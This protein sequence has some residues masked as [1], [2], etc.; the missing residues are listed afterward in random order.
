[1]EIIFLGTSSGTPTKTR[2]VSGVAIRRLNNHPLKA[3]GLE[4]LA[5]E[6]RDT[7]RIALLPMLTLTL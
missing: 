5:T 7:G 4:S 6:S 2:N 3:G 1:M